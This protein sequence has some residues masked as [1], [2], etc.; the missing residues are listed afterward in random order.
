MIG[1]THVI[2]GL[3]A[4]A[5]LGRI[6]GVT[7]TLVEFL[8]LIVG[9]LAPDIDGRGTIT[10]PGKIL[11]PF[12][13]RRL[14]GLIDGLVGV[15]TGTVKMCFGHRGFI[16]APLLAVVFFAFGAVFQRD[17][18]TWFAFGYALHLVGDAMTV[19]G[20]P[21]WSPFS[22]RRM[23]FARIRTGS[24]TEGAIATGLVLLTIVFGWSVLPE[25]VKAAQ[26][27]LF[28]AVWREAGSQ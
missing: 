7:P 6:T 14:G 21:V 27:N 20:I 2:S 4:A 13:G 26:R 12:L 17:W 1:P 24:R 16:H 10:R 5:A 25:G 22:S 11:R 23:S 15:V 3:A 28:E 19:E 18:V 8:A 9:T